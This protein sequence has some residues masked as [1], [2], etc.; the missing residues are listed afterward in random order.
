MSGIFGACQPGS[1]SLAATALGMVSAASL[2]GES[3]RSLDGQGAAFALAHRWDFQQLGREGNIYV[4]ADADLI[5]LAE[6]SEE[7][8]T[9][10][11]TDCVAKVI[12]RLYAKYGT[13]C[14]EHM[15]GAFAIA[16]WDTAERQL[17]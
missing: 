8:G 4:A 2:E 11:S 6:L 14:V 17:M 5:N 12:A 13:S 3:L 1:R 7:V 15:N 16:I 10:R 9:E